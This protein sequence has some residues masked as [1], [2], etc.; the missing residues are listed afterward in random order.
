[1]VKFSLGCVPVKYFAAGVTYEVRCH[2]LQYSLSKLSQDGSARRL[3]TVVL[4][5][6]P[7]DSLVRH[8]FAPI[9]TPAMSYRAL[10]RAT[11][12]WTCMVNA[13]LRTLQILCHPFIHLQERKKPVFVWLFA[14]V[15]TKSDCRR[16]VPFPTGVLYFPNF[17]FHFL[18]CKRLQIHVGVGA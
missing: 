5:T 2:V 8:L 4:T 3:R 14:K 15:S 18:F 9:C 6:N 7:G 11:L 1:M 12:P 17:R 13:Y 10:S 16:T